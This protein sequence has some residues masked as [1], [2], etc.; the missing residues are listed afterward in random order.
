MTGSAAPS[1]ARHL[2]VGGS[3]VAGAGIVQ[4]LTDDGDEPIFA[5]ARRP[6][7]DPA[8]EGRVTPL[9]ADL[10]DPVGLKAALRRAQPSHVYYAAHGSPGGGDLAQAPPLALHPRALQA[11]LRWLRPLTPTLVRLPGAAAWYFGSIHAR[12]GLRDGGKNGLMFSGL[13]KALADFARESGTRPHLAV[14]TGGRLHGVHLGPSLWPDY[15]PVITAESPRPPG[16]T[17]YWDIEDPLREAEALPY[18]WSIHRPHF[19][20]GRSEGAPLSLVD[21]IACYALLLRHAGL[22][23]IFPG[24][25]DAFAARGDAV[26]ATLLGAQMRWAAETPAAHGEAFLAR[27]GPAWRWPEVWPQ[28]AADFGMAW[29]VPARAVSLYD[30]L[31]SPEAVWDDLRSRAGLPPLPLPQAMPIA[32]L[33]QAMVVTW[34]VTYDADK[35]AALGFGETRGWQGFRAALQAVARPFAPAGDANWSAAPREFDPLTGA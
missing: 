2:V 31:P 16:R 9:A 3:G 24:G 19:I 30:L 22:P 13:R 20:L 12:A 29:Q 21:A 26:D 6:R 1:S 17:W 33:H 28:I 10:L 4:A 25:P 11:M 15:T 35:A 18:S 14:V 8:W 32:F 34:D 23:L 27:N 5:L 7:L